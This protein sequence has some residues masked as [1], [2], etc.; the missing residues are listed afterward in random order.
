MKEKA[1]TYKLPDTGLNVKPYDAN[2]VISPRLRG[3]GYICTMG[4]ECEDEQET[5]IMT[6]I[7]YRTKTEHLAYQAIDGDHV[8]AWREF[9][10][11][12]DRLRREAEQ[13][14]TSEEKMETDDAGSQPAYYYCIEEFDVT[15]G[16]L[17]K[18]DS[19]LQEFYRI[20][21]LN[22]IPGVTDWWTYYGSPGSFAPFHLEDS[23]CFS[24][25]IML[26]GK[27]KYWIIVK[28]ADAD[29]FEMMMSIIISY[30]VKC[31][32]VLRHKVALV[33][34]DVLD[35]YD[36]G[37][38]LVV[39]EP[40]QVIITMPRSYHMIWNSSFNLN[41]AQNLIGKSWFPEGG[42]AKHCSCGVISIDHQARL[43]RKLMMQFY[44]SEMND[45]PGKNVFFNP[46]IYHVDEDKN[47]EY[48]CM[49]KDMDQFLEGAAQVKA[50]Q[51]A[52]QAKEEEKKR[53]K[54]L[55]TKTGQGRPDDHAKFHCPGCP[56]EPARKKYIIRHLKS[57]IN[58]CA[59]HDR[60]KRLPELIQKFG[61]G[62]AFKHGKACHRCALG[63][64]VV[65]L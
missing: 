53:A 38:T 62:A 23:N 12:M 54:R 34:T 55:I 47:N 39:Q 15:A 21:A 65:C 41:I 25:N 27:P 19:P 52:V 60:E 4:M 22:A 51:D 35:E 1:S 17:L 3:A 8:A 36:I 16:K 31:K 37:Y 48:G 5:I 61:D 57:E 63:L 30:E 50:K 58:S 11:R 20:G 56:R 14:L 26:S 45:V 18:A 9:N 28:P 42:K 59:L 33:T 24:I 10:G 64:S 40:G 32:D 46:T 13:P 2:F 44:A 43:P 49:A 29:R 6:D 7:E